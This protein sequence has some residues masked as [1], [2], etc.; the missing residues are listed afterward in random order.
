[1]ASSTASVGESSFKFQMNGLARSLILRQSRNAKARKGEGVDFSR[2]SPDDRRVMKKR[3]SV[4]KAVEAVAKALNGDVYG[5]C[6]TASIAIYVLAGGRSSGL[7]L[8]STNSPQPHFWLRGPHN[9]FIDVTAGQFDRP[10]YFYVAGKRTRFPKHI[11]AS[12][13]NLID[14][15]RRFLLEDS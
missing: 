9:E 5:E 15:A 3:V 11:K 2:T 10:G 6:Y 4:W 14:R 8:F 12:E 1:M 13:R 7:K